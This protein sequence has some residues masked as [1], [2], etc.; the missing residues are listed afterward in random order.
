MIGPISAF[1][2]LHIDSALVS[3]LL[4]ILGFFVVPLVTAFVLD[5]I[6]RKVLRLYTNDI[7]KFMG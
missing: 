5:I 1:K 2:F 3:V 7:Y 6:F 4:I